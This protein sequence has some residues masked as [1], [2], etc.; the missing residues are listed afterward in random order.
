MQ[1][2]NQPFLSTLNNQTS[3]DPTYASGGNPSPIMYS[4]DH[5]STQQPSR[6]V[7]TSKRKQVK[8]ACTNCQKACKKCDEG[9]ACQR[10]IKLGIA[11][12]C[13][14]SPRRDRLKGVKRGPYKKRQ[15]QKGVTTN[16]NPLLPNDNIL[17]YEQTVAWDHNTTQSDRLYGQEMAGFYTRPPVS[18]FTPS[19]RTDQYTSPVA[20]SLSTSPASSTAVLTQDSL[21][22]IFTVDETMPDPAS[23]PTAA[24]FTGSSQSTQP[25]YQPAYYHSQQKQQEQAYWDPTYP[26]SYI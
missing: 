12:T 5:P 22:S 18:S 3:N 17:Q 2:G 1:N 6:K 10:C 25:A 26:Q 4:D 14:D 20:P 11:D 21:Q 8:N 15:Q 13:I 23:W 9:R 7:K 19:P 16:I 24:T